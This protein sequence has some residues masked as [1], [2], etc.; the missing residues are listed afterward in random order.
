M[1]VHS[2]D[3]VHGAGEDPAAHGHHAAASV[4]PAQADHAP[5]QP[6]HAA[7]RHDHEPDTSGARYKPSAVHSYAE[8]LRL[9]LLPAVGDARLSD[10]R[11]ANP[12]TIRNRAIAT[13]PGPV[14]QPPRETGP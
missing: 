3:R 11:R 4:R 2:I 5:D 8:A 7:G 6:H 10:V 9:R 14:G 13:T 12:S 1:P